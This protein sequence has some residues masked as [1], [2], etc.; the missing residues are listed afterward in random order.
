MKNAILSTLNYATN[1][2]I[3]PDI[4]GFISADFLSRKF[5]STVVGTYDSYIL[6]LADGIN[7]EDCLFVDCDMNRDNLV[8]IGNHMR[9]KNDNMSS[10]SF[11]PNIHY[12]VKRYSS[13]FPYATCYL[14]SASIELD[15]SEADLQRMAY[16]DSTLINMIKYSDNM[17]S[18]SSRLR[19]SD[20]EGIINQ[21]IDISDMSNKYKKQSFVS[22]N[23]G[24]ERYIEE[25]NNAL[26]SEGIKH[27]PITTG[28]RY[29]NDKV[30]RNTVVEYN[31]DIISYAQ[32]YSDEFSV[33]YDREVEWK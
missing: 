13:K 3:S 1:I 11:N 29:K 6:C 9:L 26:K 21:T 5:G 20:I 24:K 15:L 23:Y 31:N 18:W 14:I 30:G 10:R 32:I 28:I 33:T 27:I 22:K 2:I 7:P 12:D 19:H 17:Q 25:I 16:A 4:D 8:S